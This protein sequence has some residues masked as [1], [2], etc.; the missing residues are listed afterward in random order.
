MDLFF[1]LLGLLLLA[2]P[3]IAITALVKSVGLGEHLR[4]VEARLAVLE[5]GKAAVMPPAPASPTH[6]P[7][8]RAA[9]PTISPASTKASHSSGLASCCWAS[10]GSTSA[11]C[12][13]AS[14]E[15]A[16]SPPDSLAERGSRR[17]AGGRLTV[18]HGL[19]FRWTGPVVRT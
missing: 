7:V 19:K 8:P 9:E 2:F 16:P 5:R 6:E 14:R 10:A 1:V 13:H 4:R 18:K 3:I 12:S 15:P 17:P 11:S